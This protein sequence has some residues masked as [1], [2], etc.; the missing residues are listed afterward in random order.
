MSGIKRG[1]AKKK[2]FVGEKC[3]SSTHPLSDGAREQLTRRS[4]HLL[5]AE[6]AV[7]DTVALETV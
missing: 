2:D 1:R 7:S 3:V 6:L 5:Q 4:I